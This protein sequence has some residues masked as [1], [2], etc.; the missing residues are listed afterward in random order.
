MA[1]E[2]YVSDQ[3]AADYRL[4]A[5]ESHGKIRFLY[6]KVTTDVQGDANSEFNLGKLP[7]GAVRILPGLS[8]YSCSALSTSRVLT[9]GHRAYTKADGADDQAEDLDAFAAGIDASGAIA[10]AALGT[11]IK[12]D[13]FSKGGITVAAQ[14][15]GGTV[16][17]SAVLEGYIAYVCE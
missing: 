3:M 7:F 16:P 12:H 4:R 10:G 9:F 5:F 13:L 8:R 15:T 17:A 11:N 1:V 14:V 6:F 2:T